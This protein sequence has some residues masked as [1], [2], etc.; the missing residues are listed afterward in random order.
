MGGEFG[1]DWIHVYIWLSHIYMTESLCCPPETIT[2]LLIAYT[3]I[4]NSWKILISS[5]PAPHSRGLSLT[6][7]PS[8]TNGQIL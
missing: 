3:P 5:D 1:G 7:A 4:E 8:E 2:T 6:T